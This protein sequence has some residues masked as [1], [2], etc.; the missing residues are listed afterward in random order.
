MTPLEIAAAFARALDAD[1]FVA[2]QAMIGKGC[3]YRLQRETIEGP[4]AI[5]HSYMENARRAR[6][7][8]DEVVYRSI[9]EEREGAF[10]IRYTDRIRCGDEWHEYVC[11]QH[12]EIESAKIVAIEHRELEGEREKLTAFVTKIRAAPPAEQP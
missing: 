12:L 2:A 4:L 6:D 1:D 5:I 10:V 9:V 3:R 8:F 11:E 7:M